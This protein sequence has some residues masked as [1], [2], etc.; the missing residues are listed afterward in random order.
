MYKNK[1]NK[2][3]ISS[4]D[5]VPDNMLFSYEKYLIKLSW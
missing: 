4:M 1:K 5:F 3:H 2:E